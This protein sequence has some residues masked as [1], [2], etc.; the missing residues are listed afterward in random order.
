MTDDL[1]TKSRARIRRRTA[2]AAVFAALVVLT[3]LVVS[4]RVARP[5][6]TAADTAPEKPGITLRTDVPRPAT[7][8][9]IARRKTRLQDMLITSFGRILPSGWEHS[10]FNFD[11]DE[12]HCW[13]EGDIIDGAG[14]VKL[15]ASA[16]GDIWASSCYQPQCRKK[17]LADGTL[18]VVTTTEDTLYTGASIRRVSIVGV[19][20]D[21][22]TTALSAEW[23]AD[24]PT[25][26]LP[27]DQW[28]R[29]GTAFKY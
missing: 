24:R 23:P 3:A 9:E 12:I 22:T 19:R 20:P 28:L 11:C 27:D 1:I 14:T 21:N 5:S 16:W 25:P 4:L 6:P 15:S 26:P 13:A 8:D 2:L 18:V 10:T 17:L 7:V 29:F